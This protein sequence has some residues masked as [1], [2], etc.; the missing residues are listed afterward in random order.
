MT[1][2]TTVAEADEAQETKHEPLPDGIYFGL[3]EK[4]YHADPALGSSLI[5]QLITDPAEYWWDQMVPKD[6][7][8]TSSRI[9]GSAIHKYVLEGS[10]AFHRAY[11]VAKLKANTKDGRAEAEEIRASGRIRIKEDDHARITAA[12]TFIRANPHVSKAFGGGM[13]E[14]SMFRTERI[15]DVDVRLKARFDYLKPR[16][17]V[18]LKS[19]AP[20]ADASFGA[21]WR[22]AIR[23]WRY[24]VQATAYLD[25]R[26]HLGRMVSDGMVYGDHDAAWL[27]RVAG[28]D[29]SAFAFVFWASSGAPLS[30]GGYLSPGNPMLDRGRRDVDRGLEAYVRCVKEFGPDTAWITPEPFS[31]LD[32]ME[33]LEW[34]RVDAEKL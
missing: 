15:G 13:P 16:S 34:W 14:V 32:E 1:D 22:R 31:E 28:N 8:D 9:F 11:G 24:H 6:R 2:E 27:K 17:I 12:G 23:Y 18:D 5:K 7:P 25:M 3:D 4:R 30:G 10:D 21:S 26:A 20:F 33:V 19:V 29:V